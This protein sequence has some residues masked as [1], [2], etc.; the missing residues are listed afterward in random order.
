MSAVIVD[1]LRKGA[2]NAPADS[3]RN[4]PRTRAGIP[5]LDLPRAITTD[6]VL[7]SDDA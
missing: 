6:D 7:R 2:A 1:L 4:A 3:G 5:L